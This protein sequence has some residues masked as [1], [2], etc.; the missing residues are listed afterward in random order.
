MF[1]M[2]GGHQIIGHYEP[3]ETKPSLIIV[4]NLKMKEAF[5]IY[6]EFCCFDLTYHLIKEKSH[7]ELKYGVGF[8][9]GIKNNYKITPFAV[10]VTDAEF[11]ERMAKI[12]LEFFK[13]MGKAPEAIFTD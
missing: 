11:K 5:Q 13:L 10:V 3:F 6:G 4:S 7:S 2:F 9:V 1:N 8:I 12:F